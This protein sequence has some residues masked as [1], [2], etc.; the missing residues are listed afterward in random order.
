MF[1][2]GHTLGHIRIGWRPQARLLVFAAV[3]NVFD[4][5][6]IASTAGVLDLARNPSATSLFLPG[7]GRAFTFGL[8][9]KR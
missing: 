5:R 9:W 3:R 4:R 8:E 6:H 7:P 2:D 1:Y